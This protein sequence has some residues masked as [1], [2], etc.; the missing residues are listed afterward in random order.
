ML[1]H[2][3]M[4]VGILMFKVVMVF[5]LIDSRD[6]ARCV[7]ASSKFCYIVLDC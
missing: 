5:E 4:N 1:E 7:I 2:H 6:I 3:G